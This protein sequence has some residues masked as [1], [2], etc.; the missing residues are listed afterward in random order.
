[1]WKF[2]LKTKWVK[3]YLSELESLTSDIAT[4]GKFTLKDEDLI[5]EIVLNLVKIVLWE[6]F[7]S[8]MAFI[9]LVWIIISNF[10]K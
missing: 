3:P 6:G 2:L 8:G 10:I 4:R 5:R 9:T 1:M 7:W